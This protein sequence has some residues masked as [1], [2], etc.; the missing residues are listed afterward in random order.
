LSAVRHLAA[1]NKFS[2]D[3]DN[4]KVLENACLFCFIYRR[5]LPAKPLYNPQSQ[6]PVIHLP[7]PAFF[8]VFQHR[9]ARRKAA[10]GSHINLGNY[11][12]FSQACNL[13]HC[14]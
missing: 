14:F 11:I 10:V 3:V 5:W 9:P 4:G 8:A 7:A 2:N 12:C 6:T 1:D 13:D